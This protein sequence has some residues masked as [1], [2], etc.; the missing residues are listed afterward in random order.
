MI[1]EEATSLNSVTYSSDNTPLLSSIVPRFGSVL[2][3]ESITLTGTNFGTSGGS[4]FFDNRECTI[5]SHTDTEIVCTTSD[6]PYVADTPCVMITIDGYGSV[7]TQGLVF[8]YI[9]RWSDTETWGGDI[10]PIEGESISIPA[11]QH[12]LVDVD[13][14]PQLVAIIVEGSL[15][16]A[17]DADPT[18]V[19]TFDAG[20]IMVSGGYMEVGTEDFP[21][22]SKIVITM[23]GDRWS[24]Y[25]PIYGN[26]VIGI[27]FGILDMH[28]VER[29]VVWTRL[30]DT[31]EAGDTSI[32]LI[33]SVD[34]V[35]GEEIVIAGTG[36]HNNDAETRIITA[37]SGETFSFDEPLVYMHLSV[38]PTYDGVEMPMRA[39][40][41]LLTRNV[42]FRG[43]PV[44]SPK[45]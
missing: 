30:A 7:A 16:F 32:T 36:W 19:R 44:V 1:G 18:H 17:P 29:D 23:Y 4:V 28:G 2:G 24:P 33:E 35:V 13:S 15:I 5:D 3:G 27:R 12:L 25:L 14:T 40:V 11:G 37:V 9:S 43:D 26:K 20:Y 39:E 10:P 38:A 41:G 22:T 8:M 6:K 42:V 21:Y 31:A 34:W 45:D